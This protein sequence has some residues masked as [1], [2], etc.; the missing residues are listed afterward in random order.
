[1]TIS[2]GSKLPS[3]NLTATTD[4]PFDKINI[5]NVFVNIQQDSYPKKW[6]VLFFYP[7][8]LLSSALLN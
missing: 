1:M 5:D 3:F 2:V 7:K 4:L 8:D 6:L